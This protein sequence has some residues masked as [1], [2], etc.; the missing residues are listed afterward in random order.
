MEVGINGA[1]KGSIAGDDF[2]ETF[3]S[4]CLGG[5]PQTLELKRGPLG[6]SCG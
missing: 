6:A 3:L 5:N 2:A 1:V 4:I